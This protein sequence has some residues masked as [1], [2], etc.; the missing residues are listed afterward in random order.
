VQELVEAMDKGERRGRGN[1]ENFPELR[2]R[3]RER[4]KNLWKIFHRFR[5]RRGFVPNWAQV[6]L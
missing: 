6:L 4:I 2:G 5:L 1:Q 3:G